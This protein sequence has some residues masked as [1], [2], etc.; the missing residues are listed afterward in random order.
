MA[1]QATWLSDRQ[2]RG[3]RLAGGSAGGEHA[4]RAL[5]Q[6]GPA[7]AVDVEREVAAQV[8]VAGLVIEDQPVRAE[9]LLHRAVPA[10]VVAV[11]LRLVREVAAGGALAPA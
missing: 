11:A 9:T 6:V 7:L 10:L 8:L 4:F 1:K 2:R 5:T 3:S